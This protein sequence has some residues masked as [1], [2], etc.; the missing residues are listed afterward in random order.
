MNRNKLFVVVLAGSLLAAC[1]S[2]DVNITPTTIDNSVDNST[3]GGG[4]GSEDDI[5]ASYVRDGATVQGSAD[6]NGN[7]VYDNTF[8]GPKNNLQEDLLIPALPD[9]GAHIFTASLFVGNT[10]RTQAELQAA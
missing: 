8:V 6:G 2:G 3:G 5:C 1:E 10:F 7:C 4:G 9:G